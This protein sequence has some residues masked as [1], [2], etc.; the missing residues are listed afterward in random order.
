[1]PNS[2]ERALADA[3]SL[4]HP[5]VPWTP[6]PRLPS[7]QD[8]RTAVAVLTV[9]P[10]GE[11]HASWC[12]AKLALAFESGQQRLSPDATK[13]RAEVW[14]EANA[15]L[16]D[17]LWSKAT[18]AAIRALKWMP[19]PA[20]FREMVRAELDD[21]AKKLDRCRRMLGALAPDTTAAKPFQRE[22]LEVR[23]R[24]LRD[25]NRRHGSPDRAAKYEREL[26]ALEKREPEAW[27]CEEKRPSGMGENLNVS[28]SCPGFDAAAAL[29]ASPTARRCAE[30]AAEFR[31][32]QMRDI[33]E[34][35]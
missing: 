32:D 28:D 29:K 16:G 13:L 34:V 31:A 3:L 26:A 27:A 21:R 2:V 7:A 20:E 25:A 5:D 6:P 10:T 17:E 1:M 23:L 30:L 33:A 24:T 4:E 14:L 19:K 9:A 8:L 22:P 18:L 12:L 11:K 35:A 15:D